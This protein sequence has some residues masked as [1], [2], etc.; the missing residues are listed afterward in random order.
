MLQ[1]VGKMVAFINQ[2]SFSQPVIISL[3][4]SYYGRFVLAPFNI[5]RYNVLTSHGPDLY[6][7]EPWTFYFINS[8]LNFNFIAVAAMFTPLALVSKLSE[9]SSFSLIFVCDF[10]FSLRR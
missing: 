2:F 1:A 10:D 9:W 8:V 6:G 4:S 3:D 7:T 5:V